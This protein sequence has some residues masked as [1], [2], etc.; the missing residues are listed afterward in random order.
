MYEDY[1]ATGKPRL[2]KTYESK[3][4]GGIYL[5]RFPKLETGRNDILHGLSSDDKDV[6]KSDASLWAER[7]VPMGNATRPYGQSDA[8][9]LAERL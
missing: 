9:L 8:S 6:C 5:N 1:Q 7:R 3:E 4:S 2:I